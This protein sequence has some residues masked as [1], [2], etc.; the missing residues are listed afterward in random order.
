MRI[1]DLARA[2]GVS[3]RLLRYYEEQ[4]LLRPV[5]QPNG[6]RK[7]VR[8]DIA[9]VRNI[10]ILLA[11]GLSTAAIA[12]ILH[13]VHDDSGQVVPS[14][15]P[16]M[17]SSLRHERRRIAKLIERL[18]AS[19]HILDTLLTAATWQQDADLPDN[20]TGTTD[21]TRISGSRRAAVRSR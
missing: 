6:Y 13:C 3:P 17:I 5:R 14:T 11:A 20:A 4:G 16:G 21:V 7:Y 18:Q 1:G 19:Q 2:T 12:R 8:S 9:A 10:R 15:C